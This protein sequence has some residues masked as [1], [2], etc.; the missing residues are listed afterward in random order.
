MPDGLRN[1][2]N[3]RVDTWHHHV[4]SSPAFEKVREE[5]LRLA[6]VRA[7]DRC[8]DLGAGTGFLT[9]PLAE[10]AEH[11]TAVDIS[12][13]MAEDLQQRALE[14]GRDNVESIAG[15]LNMLRM[16]AASLDVIVSNYALHHV[17]HPQKRELVARVHGWL[18]P[19]GRLVVADMMFGRGLG[20]EDRKVLGAKVK[21]LAAKGPGGVWRIAKNVTRLGLRLGDEQ[22]APP[23]FWQRAF[24]DA[25]FT[26]VGHIQIINEAGIVWGNAHAGPPTV[27]DSAE[28]QTS[29]DD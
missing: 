20:A 24:T 18:K 2:W 23:D 14:A 25:G 21:A 12:P 8:L 22:P 7:T 1:T 27:G 5:V 11:V 16:P 19:G 26:D 9:L 13:A 6:D 15:D 17:T 3:E 29:A 10:R 28:S 4:T